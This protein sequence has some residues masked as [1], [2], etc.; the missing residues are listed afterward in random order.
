[1]Q[2]RNFMHSRRSRSHSFEE[3][4][5]LESTIIANESPYDHESNGSFPMLDG[6]VNG[7]TAYNEAPRH[8]RQSDKKQLPNLILEI[9]QIRWTI[10]FPLKHY[11]QQSNNNGGSLN[12]YTQF[13]F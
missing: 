13:P 1:M 5:T 3:A 11:M 8:Y 4:L 7:R 2:Y 10:R 9:S 6:D 12:E